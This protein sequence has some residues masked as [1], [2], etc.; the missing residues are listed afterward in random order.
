MLQDTV[1][2]LLSR[3]TTTH[4]EEREGELELHKLEK[5]D[6]PGEAAASE[7]WQPCLNT[8]PSILYVDFMT[9]CILQELA[10]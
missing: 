3:P 5:K 8:S 6:E 7:R 1:C 2:S 9:K 10:G 4:M